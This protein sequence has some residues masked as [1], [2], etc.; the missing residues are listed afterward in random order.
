[1]GL[2]RCSLTYTGAIASHL[3]VGNMNLGELV[4]LCIATGLTAASWAL[5]PPSR[6]DLGVS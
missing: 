1:M 3:A 6:R 4:F 5:R 2:R